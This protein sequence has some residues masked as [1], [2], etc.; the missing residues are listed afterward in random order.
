MVAVPY[1]SGSAA[2]VDDA[3]DG[4][5]F[6]LFLGD[7][8]FF[9]PLDMA[10]VHRCNTFPNCPLKLPYGPRT[11]CSAAGHAVPDAASGA[12]CQCKTSSCGVPFERQEGEGPTLRCAVSCTAKQGRRRSRDGTTCECAENSYDTEMNGAVICAA[13][14]WQ[15]LHTFKEYQDV[16]SDREKSPP[17][18][19]SKC[20]ACATCTNGVVKLHKG[21]RLNA[22]SSAAMAAL[23]ERG[24]AGAPQVAF[25]CPFEDDC[26]EVALSVPQGC[27]INTPA[28]PNNTDCQRNHDGPLCA[29]CR[30]NYSKQG[31]AQSECAECWV[32]ADAYA[33]K[34]FGM[35]SAAFIATAVGLLCSVL[36]L[37]Y[38]QRNRLSH[39]KAELSINLRIL[40]GA[41][42]VLSL[43]SATLDLVYP[44]GTQAAMSFSAV[45]VANAFSLFRAECWGWSYQQIWMRIVWVGPALVLSVIVCCVLWYQW[46]GRH[47]EQ[48]AAA[49]RTALHQLVWNIVFFAIVLLYPQVS[50]KI[51]SALQCRSLGESYAVLQAD[52]AVKCSTHAFGFW[53][54]SDGLALQVTVL[55]LL[56]P[57]GIPLT[58]CVVFRRQWRKNKALWAA[59][60]NAGDEQQRINLIADLHAARPDTCPPPELVS[61]QSLPEFHY[62]M[63]RQKYA[64]FVMDYKVESWWYEPVDMIRKLGL[65]GLLLFVRRGTVE[66]VCFRLQCQLSILVAEQRFTHHFVCGPHTTVNGIVTS[67]RCLLL[68]ALGYTRVRACGA[69]QVLTGCCLAFTS[70]GMQLLLK[71]YREPEANVLKAIIDVQIFLVFLISFVLR[72]APDIRIEDQSRQNFASL[73]VGSIVVMLIS[74][75]ILTIRLVRRRHNFRARLAMD[76]SAGFEFPARENERDTLHVTE[77]EET[78]RITMSHA[79][80]GGLATTMAQLRDDG[81]T[82]LRGRLQLPPEAEM[83]TEMLNTFTIGSINER[84]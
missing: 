46:R 56:V 78:K 79:L 71:P 32:S 9:A 18:H 19:C 55:T 36:L 17:L 1:I 77:E 83:E 24:K 50:S 52:Y 48:G 63:V 59:T 62:C 34:T 65:T 10:G 42:Q 66:Q 84:M 45:F 73:L 6:R 57:I 51:L 14:Q 75:T 25:R 31:F 28:M 70:F 53:Q 82:G 74:A 72:V 29:A 40:F 2:D 21:W 20:P 60:D 81:D 16:Q 27:E 8:E 11:D 38:F 39:A 44:E 33:R 13:G 69:E 22:S 58:L 26:P 54:I 37:C 4:H 64:V 15:E 43:V 76:G 80:H 7:H 12:S 3:A 35:S 47:D 49:E 23:I 68:G 61:F 5:I 41:A 67:S 30:P